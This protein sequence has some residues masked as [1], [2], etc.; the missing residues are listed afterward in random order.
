MSYASEGAGGVGVGVGGRSVNVGGVEK[1][2]G[3]REKTSPPSPLSPEKMMSHIM[4]A[5]L[6]K[7]AFVPHPARRKIMS[8]ITSALLFRS[9]FGLP[10]PHLYPKPQYLT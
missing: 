10:F 8:R 3:K 9:A 1:V 5:L 4:L 7:S 6:F 2:F